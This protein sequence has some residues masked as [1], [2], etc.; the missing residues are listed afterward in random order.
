[1]TVSVHLDRLGV[2]PSE[3]SYPES[4]SDSDCDRLPNLLQFFY[5]SI[6]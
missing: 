6:N 3:K 5:S 2:L 4:R 1:M